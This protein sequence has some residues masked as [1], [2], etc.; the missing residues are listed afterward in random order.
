MKTINLKNH[1]FAQSN[2][3]QSHVSKEMKKIMTMTTQN[4]AVG[5]TDEYLG[6][7][8]IRGTIL[9]ELTE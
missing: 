4:H 6:A 8:Q 1:S 5:V 9:D 3:R 7:T 2:L